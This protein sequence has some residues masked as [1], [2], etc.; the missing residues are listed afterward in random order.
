MTTL[1][2]E[3]P[4][5][6]V[7][8]LTTGVLHRAVEL[9]PHLEVRPAG[10][11]PDGATPGLRGDGEGRHLD[12]GR[13]QGP[14][15]PRLPYRL[16]PRVGELQDLPRLSYPGPPGRLGKDGL[17]DT[18]VSP[19]AQARV[20]D[21]EPPLARQP[22][23]AVDDR[24]LEGRDRE[25]GRR[26]GPVPRRDVDRVPAQRGAPLP[27]HL[28]L[29]R[30]ADV[31]LLGKSVDPQPVQQRCRL[32]AEAVVGV[33]RPGRGDDPRQHALLPLQ[34]GP[35]LL[36][37]RAGVLAAPHPYQLT[38][39]PSALDRGPSRLVVGHDRRQ[40]SRSWDACVPR[41]AAVAS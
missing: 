12:S 31:D 15:Q 22:P 19:R 29:P 36:G 26:R 3:Q 2:G 24:A 14:A 27:A 8:V 1:L 10:V 13:V 41:S 25:A 5:A 39:S 32:V 28:R 37:R 40:C 33:Q 11:H 7:A 20:G 9:D 18:T 17:G 23:G 35:R 38:A 34:R 6:W 30:L 21:D 4:L 16:R